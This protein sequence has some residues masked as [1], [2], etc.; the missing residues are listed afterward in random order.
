MNPD[1]LT[2]EGFDEKQSLRVIQEMIRVSQNKLKNDGILFILWGWL[3][4]VNSLGAFLKSK[5]EIPYQVKTALSYL[6]AAIFLSIAIYSIYYVLKQ[7]KKVQTY[8]GVSLRYVWIS[9]V[10]SL[11][12]INVIQFNVLGTFNVR[13]QHAIFMVFMAFAILITGGILRYDKL[14]FGGVIFGFLAFVSSYL[15]IE[16]QMLMESIGW[17]FA[18]IIPGH[19]LYA[20]RDKK[21]N[22]V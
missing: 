17:L 20:K 12:I 21:E 5:I 6:M 7:R 19:S 10:V 18:F 13:L 14:I 15:T 1:Q 16:N 9:F 11:I 8:I 3:L 2:N 22:H 4:F